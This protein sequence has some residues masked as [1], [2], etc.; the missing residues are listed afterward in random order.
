[1]DGVKAKGAGWRQGG[2]GGG[3]WAWAKEKSERAQRRE[4]NQHSRVI[5]KGE[6]GVGRGKAAP[7]MEEV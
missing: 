4:H 1:M 7:E 5:R 3:K 6:A 2:R